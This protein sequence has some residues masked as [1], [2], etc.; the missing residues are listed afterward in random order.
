MMQEMFGYKCVKWLTRIEVTDSE[1]E[2]GTYQDQGFVDDGEIRV[3]SRMTDPID[4]ITVGSGTVRCVGFAVSGAAG[5]QSVEL[6]ID[7]GPFIAAAI[8]PESEALASDPLLGATI[9]ATS[10]ESFPYPYRGV[11]VKW[12]TTLDLSPGEHIIRIR[13]T[14]KSGNVQPET[15]GDISD[16]INAVPMVHVKAI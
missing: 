6:S 11:W 4:N 14:D 7:N 10:P 12:E 1:E 16:G 13:A 9:Q 2:F 15:D 3:I 8:Q 5:I